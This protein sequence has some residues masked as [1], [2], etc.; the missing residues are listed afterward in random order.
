[1]SENRLT[2]R[3]LVDWL[4]FTTKIHS[5]E[6]IIHFLGLNVGLNFQTIYGMHGY[7][8]R[9]YYEGI[10]IHFNNPLVEGIWVEM[11]GQGCRCFDTYSK[12][13]WAELLFNLNDPDYHVTRFDIAF[14]DFSGILDINI[15]C[16]ETIQGNYISKWNEY[17]VI[18]SSKGCTIE[19]GSMSSQIFLRIYDKAAERGRS[20]EISHWIRSE[21]QM[22][23]DRAG[24]FINRLVSVY[25]DEK[26]GQLYS[27]VI[28]QY[29]RYVKPNKNDSN[30]RR[31]ATRRW[32][33]KFVKTTDKITLWTPCD[34]EYN[35]AR[36]KRFVY[37]NAGNAI[38]A[39]IEIMGKDEMLDELKKEKPKRSLKYQMLVDTENYN[40]GR[41]NNG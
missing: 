21:I 12:S 2:D 30:K 39:L 17:K 31:W 26:I 37:N 8:Q 29:L 10:S 41:D 23:D 6:S 28:N 22:R 1:M 18:N 25:G 36:C 7:S 32:W 27:G 20:D 34:L 13:D 9:L 15:L 33:L 40:K 16:R 35:L 19:H 14:D 11:S 4:S 5:I 3:F 24:E 38:S